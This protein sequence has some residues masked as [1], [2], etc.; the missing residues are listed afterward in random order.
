MKKKRKLL[1]SLKRAITG[2]LCGAVIATSTFS[3][4]SMVTHA[5]GFNSV[6]QNTVVSLVDAGAYKVGEIAGSS[7]G[8]PVGGVVLGT[9][10]SKGANYFVNASSTGVEGNTTYNIIFSFINSFVI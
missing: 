6:I 4:Y 2:I 10:A 3:N 5:A 9:L 1:T 8:G 7:I